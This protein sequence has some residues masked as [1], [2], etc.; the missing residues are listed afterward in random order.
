MAEVE[1]RVRPFQVKGVKE[2]SFG[3]SVYMDEISMKC[4]RKSFGKSDHEPGAKILQWFVDD[5]DK[6]G[7]WCYSG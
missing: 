5:C 3:R 7:D 1:W 6:E 2:H 4:E